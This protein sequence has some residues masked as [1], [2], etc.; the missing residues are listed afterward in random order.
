MKLKQI[1]LL[2]FFVVFC[3]V[4]QGQVDAT[5]NKDTSYQFW[6]RVRFGGGV[7]LSFGNGF[8][9]GTLAP[10]T[11]YQFNN[12]FAL[13]VG[14]SG[15]YNSQRDFANTTILGGSLISLFNVIP[16]IQLSGELEQLNFNRNFEATT[17]FEDDNFW[18]TALFLGAGYTDGNFT[19]GI[20]YDVLYNE[21]RSIYA[22]AWVPFVRVF[23]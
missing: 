11:I 21:D 20:R 13:G 9:S 7:G 8:F 6:D 16:E 17:G 4:C 14:L 15:T 10:S 18:N 5:Q 1:Q 12:Q 23:F 2:I 19:V 22:N 3:Y